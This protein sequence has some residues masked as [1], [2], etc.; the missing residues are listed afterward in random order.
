[1]KST[2]KKINEKG[3]QSKIK[4]GTPA[5]EPYSVQLNGTG[6]LTRAP[7]WPTPQL[8]M[9]RIFVLPKQLEPNDRITVNCE[10]TNQPSLLRIGLVI[11]YNSPDYS[12]LACQLEMYFPPQYSDKL[13]ITKVKDNSPTI[14]YEDSAVNFYA[15]Y[16]FRM[17]FKMRDDSSMMDIYIG[18]SYL[19]T[20]EL[21]HEMANIRFLTVNGD[22][23][24]VSGLDFHFG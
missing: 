20:V 14:E 21:V 16:H 19:H 3:T 10:T 7:P 23:N 18:D 15:D 5:D 2:A 11:G 8:K 9:E 12:N 4:N 24:R 13:T 22:V 6:K 1:M 17:Q